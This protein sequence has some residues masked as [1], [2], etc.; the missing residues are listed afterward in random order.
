MLRSF[1]DGYQY[2]G[3]FLF[4]DDG[5]GLAFLLGIGDVLHSALGGGADVFGPDVVVVRDA[6]GGPDADHEDVACELLAFGEP[7]S[8][9]R[10]GPSLALTSS[11]FTGSAWVKS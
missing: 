1:S 3:D 4:L 6:L 8:D 11:M 2:R 9:T 10:A 7:P 5:D